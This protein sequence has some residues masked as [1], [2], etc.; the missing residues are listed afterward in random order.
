MH[1]GRLKTLMDVMNHYASGIK[2]SS[3]LDPLLVS[4]SI[5]LSTQEKNDLIAFLGTLTDYTFI[6][7][8]RFKE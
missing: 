8:G 3:T 5:A 4:G 7:D 1:D 2:M 6:R